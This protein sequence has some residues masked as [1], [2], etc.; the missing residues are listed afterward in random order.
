MALPTEMD[1]VGL[2]II[3]QVNHERDVQGFDMSGIK[4]RLEDAM[5][6][7]WTSGRRLEEVARQGSKEQTFMLVSALVAG[8]YHQ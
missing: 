6:R 4:T 2:A 7:E 1:S 3:T 8:Q 5:R